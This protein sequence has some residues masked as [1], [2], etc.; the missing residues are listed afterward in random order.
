MAFQIQDEKYLQDIGDLLSTGEVSNLISADEKQE[1]IEK[2][3]VIDKQRD[4]TLQTSGTPTALY[5]YYLT[6]SAG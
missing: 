5:N 1:I 3:S 6:V 4:K 2:M